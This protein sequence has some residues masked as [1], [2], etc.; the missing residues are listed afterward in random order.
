MSK[1]SKPAEWDRIYQAV[2]EETGD[3]E[4]AAA[5]ATSRAGSRFE[6][7]KDDPNVAEVVPETQKALRQ[8]VGVVSNYLRPTSRH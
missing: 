1:V 7:Q 8:A 2:L 3:K 6:K 4:K 5:I